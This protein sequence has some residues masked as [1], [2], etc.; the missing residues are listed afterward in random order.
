LITAVVVL[1][2]SLSFL[3]GDNHSVRRI[4]AEKVLG[5]KSN[6]ATMPLKEAVAMWMGAND[7][8]GAPS[9]CPRPII[10]ATAGGAS[11]A[12]FFTASVIGYLLDAAKERVPQVDETAM[13]RRL[14]A[15]SGVS[16]GSLGAVMT[17]AALARANDSGQQP[18]VKPA[19]LWYGDAINNWRDCLEALTSGDFLTA[20]AVGLVFRDTVR[21]GW[22]QDRAETLEKSW[23]DHFAELTG[24]TN[25]HWSSRCPGDLRC[26]FL[27]LRPGLPPQPQSQSQPKLRNWVPLLV[28]NGVSATTGRRIITTPLKFDYEPQATCPVEA[29][30]IAAR[31]IKEKAAGLGGIPSAASG[32]KPACAIFMETVFF[33]FLIKNR[34]PPDFFAWF[35]R[36]FVSDYLGEKLFHRPELDD[37]AISTA[38]HNSARFPIISPPGAVRNRMHQIVDRIVDGGYFENYGALSAM[39]LAVAIHAVEPKLSPFVLVVSNDPEESPDFRR[40]DAPDDA[41]LTDFSI[42]I[43]AV[44]NIRTSRGRLAV[45]QLEATMGNMLPKCGVN[46]AHI[47]VWPEYRVSGLPGAAKKVAT[48]VSMSWWLSRPIQVLL[49]QQTEGNKDQNQNGDQIDNAFRAIASKSDCSGTN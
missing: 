48:P 49:H 23:E 10:V 13:A 1:I 8:A 12:G 43:E 30:M 9:Q 29:A 40:A 45:A 19:S 26:P 27:S 17:A 22:W 38:A 16:G 31:E 33:H 41:A 47:R 11:R 32:P 6:L 34:N 14:F 42:P 37:V 4:N 39:E 36:L 46:T 35:Q 20:V 25:D 44:A 2:F 7:C 28:L 24:A 5:A 15:I 3:L 21:F 18:C